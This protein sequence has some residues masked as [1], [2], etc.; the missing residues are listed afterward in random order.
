MIRPTKLPF[1][2]L[3]CLL[4]IC[5][6]VCQSRIYVRQDAMG[7]QSGQN[8]P[9]AYSNL[10][11]A[12]HVAADGDTVWVAQGSYLPT[13]DIDRTVSFVIPRGIVLLGGFAGVENSA[14]E[15]NW[16]I[17][18]TILSGDIGI[19]DDTSDN[20]HHILKVLEA[21]S[22]TTI[23][24][25]IFRYGASTDESGSALQMN[26][27]LPGAPARLAVRNCLFQ[28]NHNGAV[29][30]RGNAG[31]LGNTLPVFE[32]CIFRNNDGLVFRSERDLSLFNCRFIKNSNLPLYAGYLQ[33]PLDIN[34]PWSGSPHVEV[35]NCIFAFN[36]TMLPA[37]A[38]WICNGT[39]NFTNC[40]F[41]EN[42]GNSIR[43]QKSKVNLYNSILWNSGVFNDIG[44]GYPSIE[45]GNLYNSLIKY[46]NTQYPAGALVN[47]IYGTSTTAYSGYYGCCLGCLS[48]GNGV[49]VPFEGFD[50]VFIDAANEDFRLDDCSAAIDAGNNAYINGLVKDLAG[51]ARI[52]NGAIDIGPFE[53]AK[54][55]RD[56]R[57]YVTDTCDACPGSF[58]RALAKAKSHPGPDT[59]RFNLSGPPPYVFHPRNSIQGCLVAE[60]DGTV[61]DG[62]TQPGYTAG[63]I[64]LD[65]S[66]LYWP[67]SGS[68]SCLKFEGY[69]LRLLG[70]DMALYGMYISNWKGAD[71]AALQ[72]LG[73]NTRLGAP[74]KGN[75]FANALIKWEMDSCK[76]ESNHF[77]VGPDNTLGPVTI[78]F[79]HVGEVRIGGPLGSNRE[80]YFYQSNINF[81]GENRLGH[82]SYLRGNTFDG[83]RI[84]MLR[85]QFG[86]FT[87]SS[88]F[89]IGGSFPNANQ[90]IGGF[91][92]IYTDS[93]IP[94]GGRLRGIVMTYNNFHCLTFPFSPT[95]DPKFQLPTPP[96]FILESTTQTIKGAA[97]PGDSV[98]VYRVDDTQCP[99]VRCQGDTVL[100]NTIADSSGHWILNQPLKYLN[101]GDRVTALTFRTDSSA[102]TSIFADCKTV[103]C[104]TSTATLPQTLC[105]GDTL[106]F[107][108]IPVTT[109]GVF[110]TLLQA[111]NGCDSLVSLI[112]SLES[113]VT[114]TL[115]DSIC[116]GDTLFIGTEVFFHPGTYTWTKPGAGACD[117]TVSL[118]LDFYPGFEITALVMPDNGSGNGSVQPTVLGGAPPFSFIWNDGDTSSQ[119]QNLFQ[120]TY[121][122]TVADAN[123][124]S[125][126]AE[127][128]VSFVVHAKEPSAL[129]DIQISP[130]P[131]SEAVTVNAGNTPEVLTAMVYNA[132]GQ[133]VLSRHFTGQLS[134][135]TDSFAAGIYIIQII[136]EKY[137]LTSTPILKIK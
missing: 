103:V 107:Q 36:Q 93:L 108:G 23:D 54:P 125:Q 26:N 113:P 77:G 90:F 55:V 75:Y 53:F 74:G 57:I 9:D 60:G 135:K 25:F 129:P 106:W 41:Y 98:Q 5:T 72:V 69:G 2:A 34:S 13:A 101:P 61:I 11:D 32:N 94:D 30:I 91:E 83:S 109:A 29:Y 111:T 88:G 64:Q 132:L 134:I 81:L 87:H 115:Q 78:K 73:N 126:T 112:V 52:Q 124:C 84:W 122:V 92:G 117:T 123:N 95:N 39:A 62:T 28:Y 18:P 59:I 130:N 65:G 47:C 89:T 40:L 97:P 37:S 35:Y 43:P 16:E 71:K 133:L 27:S 136:Q 110:D 86:N 58:R 33:N 12:L 56:C 14:P 70:N 6:V 46:Y 3:F 38:A 42:Q 121:S 20:S 67:G 85:D 119:R 4:N 80:N 116:T 68:I 50:P 102:Y 127:F 19:P 100:G 79:S 128:T 31:S 17:H 82:H 8:W 49:L 120:G 24:G 51:D 1:P 137:V 10:Q 15:R 22:G 66:H 7:A 105:A 21:N 44:I 76:M 96:V 99:G 48:G 118:Y 114:L 131:F 63:M 45:S 104:G